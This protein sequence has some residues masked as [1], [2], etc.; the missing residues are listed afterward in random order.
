MKAEYF[1]RLKDP[2]TG[3]VLTE[4]SDFQNIA[5]SHLVNSSG[6]ATLILDGSHPAISY[7]GRD[8]I[9]EFYRSVSDF[10]LDWYMEFEG[11]N[12]T[13]VRQTFEAGTRNFTA[14][15]QGYCDLLSRRIIAYKTGTDY[16]SKNDKAETVMKAFVDENI[17]PGAGN[18][19]RIANGVCTG[20]FVEPDQARGTTWQGARSFNNLLEVLQE[21]S[22]ESNIFFDVIGWQDNNFLFKVFPSVR[23]TDRRYDSIDPATG[24]N[25]AGNAPV[26]F[27]LDRGN[28][29]SAVHSENATNQVTRVFALG[30]GVE[31]AR[32]VI[33]VEDTDA[34][35]ESPWNL[36]EISREA[37]SESTDDGLTNVANAELNA[38]K[39]VN[40]FNFDVLQAEGSFYGKHY[41]WGDF[42]TGRYDDFQEDKFVIGAD[43]TVDSNNGETIKLKLAD[44]P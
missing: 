15:M 20:F 13:P 7:F 8:T 31:D 40:T 18:A 23:G 33:S 35:A 32:R 38:G 12:R 39:P 29:K 28:T 26:V 5:I 14:N 36:H 42:V 30:Q 24:F 41:T 6:Y 27:S 1:V 10:G 25:A 3:N 43:I 16:A 37:T 17:G 22:D 44:I 11:L 4:I 19:D 2:S 34:S 21:I 9:C